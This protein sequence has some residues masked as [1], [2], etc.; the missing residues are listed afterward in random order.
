MTE[1]LGVDIGGTGVKAAPV[2]IE[3][4]DLL[5]DRFRLRTPRPATPEA[6]LAALG[7][8][9]DHFEWTDLVGCA[10]PGVVRGGTIC[11]AANLH[12]SWIGVDLR[13]ALATELDLTATVVNDADAAGIA[14]LAFGT[15]EMSTGTAILCTLGTGIGTAVFADGRLLPNTEF[16]HL[17]MGGIEAEKRASARARDDLGLSWQEWSMHFTG[18]L[19]ELEKLLWPNLFVIG[20]GISKKFDKYGP[21]IDVTTPVVPAALG[22]TA[23]IVGAALAAIDA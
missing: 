5:A 2:D 4:G 10:F 16:G 17:D 11:T 7:E 20:G 6:L 21:L 22:N 8:L 13:A 14:E 12:P 1:I 18:F 19:Q 3:T 23:G 15:D 9:R